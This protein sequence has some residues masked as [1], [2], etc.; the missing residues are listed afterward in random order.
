[1]RLPNQYGLRNE[2][3]SSEGREAEQV[4]EKRFGICHS[5]GSE[6]SRSELKGLRDSSSTGLLGMTAWKRGFFLRPA[7]LAIKLVK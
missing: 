1:M 6:E 7:S 5:D 3:K 4:A 2:M